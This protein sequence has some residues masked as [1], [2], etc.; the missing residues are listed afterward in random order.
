MRFEHA[1]QILDRYG[2]DKIYVAY[3][4]RGHPH[5]VEIGRLV[6]ANKFGV[7]VHYF[8]D[9]T[10]KMTHPEDLIAFDPDLIYD[11]AECPMCGEK[12]AGYVHIEKPSDVYPLAFQVPFESVVT[13]DV[14]QLKLVPCLHPISR[15]VVIEPDEHSS[16]H[17]TKEP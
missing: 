7:F 8:S 1:I 15:I 14:S 16:T 17:T 6:S 10:A 13:P 12:I 2:P 11:P 4:P 3:R 5:D 9:H